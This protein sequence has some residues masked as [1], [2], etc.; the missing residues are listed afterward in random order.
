MKIRTFILIHFALI[1]SLT[2]S[3]NTLL[4][5]QDDWDEPEVKPKPQPETLTSKGLSKGMAFSLSVNNFGFTG[6]AHYRHVVGPMT[7]IIANLKFGA[8]RDPSEQTFQSV[9]GQQIIPNKFRRGI[10]IPLTIGVKQRIFARNIEDN[11]RLYVSGAGGPALTLLIPYFEDLNG[12]GLRNLGR[13]FF[14]PQDA[15]VEPVNDF[16]QGWDDL[17]TELGINGDIAIGVDF[18][19]NFAR[20]STIELGFDFFFYPQG[21][22]ILEPNKLVENDMGQIVTAPFNDDKKFFGTPQITLMFGGMW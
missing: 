13:P 6:A 16:F 17:T 1:L 20:I 12:D 22:Q 4:Y 14:G 9:F 7:E 19:D 15:I 18:G 5:A 3:L 2:L 8:V 21:I 11:F 10:A